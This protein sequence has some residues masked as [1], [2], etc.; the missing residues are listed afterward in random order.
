MAEY[1]KP[2][3]SFSRL[4]LLQGLP[5]PVVEDE[6]FRIFS[7]HSIGISRKKLASV[8]FQL[9]ELVEKKISNELKGV[10]GVFLFDGWTHA[11]THFLEMFLSYCVSV[12]IGENGI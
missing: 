10:R 12:S 1:D 7:K 4:I 9:E 8:I 6:E 11:E 2:M 5:L 3:H